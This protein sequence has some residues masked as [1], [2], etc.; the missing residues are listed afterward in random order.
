[1]C[2]QALIRRSIK[3][4]NSMYFLDFENFVSYFQER[5]KYNKAQRT[6]VKVQ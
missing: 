3:K 6:G 1:V 5:A 2:M 4:E